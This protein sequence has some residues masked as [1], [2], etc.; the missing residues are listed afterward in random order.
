LAEVYEPESRALLQSALNFRQSELF[1]IAIDLGC[2][3]GWSTQLANEVVKPKRMV[4]LESSERYVA[5]ARA[6]H[7]QLEFMQHDILRTPFPVEAPAFCLRIYRSRN[8]H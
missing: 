2:G 3:P 1:G 7:P 6:N 5:E 4:G 8:R